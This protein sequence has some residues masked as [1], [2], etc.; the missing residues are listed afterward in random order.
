M[1]IGN[2]PEE[3]LARYDENLDTEPYVVGKVS[4]DDKKNFVDYYIKLYPEDAALP[5][6]NLY[7]KNCD[8]WNNHQWEKNEDGEWEEWSTYNPDSKW[9]WYALGGRW[10]GMIKL[11]KGTKGT[12][13]RS[14]VFNNEV[15]IDSAMKGD[16]DNLDELK[17]FAVLKDG[18][19]YER[20]KM[21]WWGITTN[22]MDE[23]SWDK[24]IVEFLRD[25][26]DYTLISIYDCHI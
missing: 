20:G 23:T 14:G 24:E 25:L 19:W 9:D 3:Q 12:K 6:D 17:T 11:K 4:E 26:P 10:S 2:N 16:I 15:G 1:V 18:E 7:I 8:N 21:G 13:G 5:F 22:E